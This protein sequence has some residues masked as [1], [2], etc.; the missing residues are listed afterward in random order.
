MIPI[1]DTSTETIFLSKWLPFFSSKASWYCS[2]CPTNYHNWISCTAG[3]AERLP[4]HSGAGAG[5]LSGNHEHHA[6]R[7]LRS[8]CLVRDATRPRDPCESGALNEVFCAGGACFSAA[9]WVLSLPMR[10]SASP[11]CPA[12]RSPRIILNDQGCLMSL[13]HTFCSRRRKSDAVVRAVL[14]R[15]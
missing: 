2:P 6:A 7:R 3:H 9:Y 4:R 11:R 8:Q 13:L 14:H 12:L 1:H 10:L 5:G 15:L